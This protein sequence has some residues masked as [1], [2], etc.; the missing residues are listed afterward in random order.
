M[1]VA[2]CWYSSSL[3]FLSR[4]NFFP[5]TS[6]NVQATAPSNAA[7]MRLAIL[8]N[9]TDGD[10][11]THD[12]LVQNRTMLTKNTT[13]K[14]EY[15]DTFGC[16]IDYVAR[17]R[18]KNLLI[19]DFTGK[20][21]SLL[22]DSITTFGGSVS[23]PDA[24]RYSDGTY[25]YEGNRCRYPQSNLL[26][27]VHDTYWM[28]LIDKLGM[29]LGINESWAGSRVSN[30][31]ATDSGDLGPNRCISSATRIGHLDDNGTPDIILVNAGTNDIGGNVTIG[32]FN[33]ESPM[34]YT[35]EQI[36]A[37]PVDT[38]ANA[39][40]TMLIRLQKSYPTSMIVCMLPNY[41]ST[42]YTPNKADQ[43]CEIIKEACDYF[44]VKWY[45]IRT[46][47]ITMF[48]K[49]AYLPDGIHPNSNGMRLIYQELLKDFLYD[50]TTY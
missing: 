21:I 31:Q 14:P 8:T 36:A 40:R 39:Y 25:T 10:D 23:D 50:V 11:V 26:T 38:F 37:L 46:A 13:E 24:A 27:N 32:T 6:D 3:E 34:N 18:I 30:T 45:D 17:S 42:L 1:G 5:N 33:T 28:R 12:L 22:G 19:Q 9:E 4:N 43:Y 47:G 35:D 16:C 48:N 20:R 49:G 15:N 7:Y 29:V 44:G 41:T 2:L